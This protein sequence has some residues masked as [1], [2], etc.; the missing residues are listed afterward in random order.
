MQGWAAAGHE[1]G[2]HP[3]FVDDGFA[4]DFDAGYRR[5]ADWFEQTMGFPYG[6]TVRHHSLEW[7]GWVT[8][9]EIMGNWGLRMDTWYYAWGPA[10]FNPTVNSQAHGYINGSGQPMRFI[11]QLGQV[12]DVFQQSTALVDEQLVT[13]DNSEHLSIPGAVAVSQQL[14]NASQNGAY[15]AI[16]TQ[17]HIDYINFGEVYPWVEQTLQ[18]AQAQ[19]IPMWPTRSW[20]AF[21]D[22]RYGTAVTDVNWSAPDRTLSFRATL[23]VGSPALT[24]LVPG[25]FGADSVTSVV[26][27]GAVVS[28]PQF[29]VNGKTTRAITLTRPANGAARV[30]SVAYAVTTPTVNV[31]DLTVTEGHS[32]TT[33]GNVPVTLSAPSASTVTVNFSATPGTA[34]T[35]ADYTRAPGS[36][37]FAPF[38]TAQSIPVTIA[39]DLL[40]EGNHSF[41]VNLTARPTPTS[42]TGPAS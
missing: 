2:L 3:Y 33:Q 34:T 7:L 37:Q 30:V 38:Q 20:L 28:A 25:S 39:G 5:S 19:G 15:A 22:A 36:V 12:I 23:P 6:P 35:P 17:F 13:G 10:L 24:M 9:A 1:V 29:V 21:T 8:P 14:I 41:S 27:D 11:N 40:Q 18:Y 4:N 42:A 26:V 32:G 31:G 16:T